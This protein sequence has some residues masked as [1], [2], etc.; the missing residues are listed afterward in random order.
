MLNKIQI[1]LSVIAMFSFASVSNALET[2]DTKPV[3]SLSMAKKMADACEE[4][5]NA[6][7]W[8][9]NIAIVDSGADLVLFRRMP[10]AFLGSVDIAIGKAT[11]SAKLPFPTRM[12]ATLSYGENG[13]T[14]AIPGLAEVDGLI[15]FA[16]GVPVNSDGVLVAAI[17]VSG[18][19]ADQDEE[20]AQAGIDAVKDMLK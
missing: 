16:G 1:S 12:L 7:G 13:N 8:N 4:V 10:S 6:K 17:G 15:S 18:A 14:G 3:L 5:A 2:L 19:S 11:S 9:M 20:C